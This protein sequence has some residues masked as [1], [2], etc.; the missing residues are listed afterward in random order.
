MANT[1]IKNYRKTYCL[2]TLPPASPT[3]LGVACALGT[4]T[5][6]LAWGTAS[7]SFTSSADV[8]FGGPPSCSGLS[9]PCKLHCSCQATLRFKRVEL[10]RLRFGVGGSCPPLVKNYHWQ[11]VLPSRMSGPKDKSNQTLCYNKW[12][13][14]AF[15]SCLS[16]IEQVLLIAVSP[17]MQQAYQHERK[18]VRQGEEHKYNTG[19]S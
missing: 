9:K 6:G 11:Y 3:A 18:S 2:S 1:T 5:L 16:P 17:A 19:T 8:C 10:I 14:I 7:S 12:L 4:A 13:A 15:D